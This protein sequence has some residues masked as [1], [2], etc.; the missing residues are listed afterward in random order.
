[1]AVS[2]NSIPLQDLA[3]L[4]WSLQEWI[5]QI[6]DLVTG[7]S[8]TIPW[9]SV[10]K[11]GSNLT[12][13]ATKNHNSLG[14]VQGG[15]ANDYYHLTS[16]QHTQVSVATSGTYTPTLTGVA[17]VSA[18]TAYQC[19]YMRIGTVVTVSGKLD[20][21][22]NLTATSTQ[23]GISLPI[24]SNIGAAEDCAGTAFASAIAGQ[25]AAILGDSG[26]D[27]AQ[28]QFISADITN[29]PMYFTFTYRII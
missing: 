2:R 3:K 12:D 21:D 26:N 17:N 13:L 14:N 9:A 4:P 18:S 19:Q 25:G 6:A 23:L 5:R 15:A 11:A 10:N 22:P 8:G 28:M 27:R 24:A 7:T 29:Q 16:A 20:I 1:M